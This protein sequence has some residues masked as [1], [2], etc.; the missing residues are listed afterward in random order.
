MKR[1]L[2]TSSITGSTSVPI[3]W[4]F[5][6]GR[7]RASTRWSSSVTRA[8]Q[9]GSTTVVAFASAMIAGPSIASPGRVSSRAEHRR[10]VRCVLAEHAH[11]RGGRE[12]ARP[13]RA[14]RGTLGR[15]VAAPD[16][17]DRRRLD[18]QRPP[19]H[20][21][22]VA[23]QVLRVEGAL[24][25]LHR[26]GRNDQRRVGAFVAQVRAPHHADAVRR[27]ALR[28]QVL[29]GVGAEPVERGAERVHR[30]GRE[31]AA[32]PIP[33]ASR[34]GPPGPCR[35]RTAR[36]RAGG[37][38]SASCRARRRPGTRAARRRRRTRTRCTG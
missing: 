33:R 2:N 25:F 1:L 20:Q 19:F 15:R 34:S 27:N 26:A 28:P 11:A 12:R 8:C 13:R 31:T 3:A 21:E 22:R 32:R 17:L 23:L 7:M 16:R 29:D 24:H 18:H 14:L 5:G 30:V 6:R 35:R 9:P 4:R 37:R 10:V 38:R 36:R